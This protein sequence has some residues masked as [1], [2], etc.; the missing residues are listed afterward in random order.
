MT[1]ER[2]IDT[3]QVNNGLRATHSTATGS[4]QAFAD[5]I[6]PDRNDL[7]NGD[8]HVIVDGTT[9]LDIRSHLESALTAAT[10]T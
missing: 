7:L 6:S 2:T 1:F 5:T 3:A 10:R 8:G 9:G 4:D